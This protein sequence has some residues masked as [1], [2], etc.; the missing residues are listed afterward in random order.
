MRF[1]NV[2][3]VASDPFAGFEA[4]GGVEAQEFGIV[5]DESELDFACFFEFLFDV[6]MGLC[7]A[8]CNEAHFDLAE[9]LGRECDECEPLSCAVVG[10]EC[11]V[12]DV[13]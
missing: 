3:V 10:R 1:D 8:S 5:G 9:L 2:G 6:G 12:Q 11:D 4:Y 7:F 13:D